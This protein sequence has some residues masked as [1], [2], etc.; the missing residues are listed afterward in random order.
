MV[1]VGSNPLHA[2]DAISA[3]ALQTLG[4][5]LTRTVQYIASTRAPTNT[6]KYKHTHGQNTPKG[7]ANATE[8]PHRSQTN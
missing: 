6:H 3:N 2:L 8:R 5:L 7:A 4:T 1:E